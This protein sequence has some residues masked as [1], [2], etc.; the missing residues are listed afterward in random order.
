[1]GGHNDEADRAFDEAMERGFRRYCAQAPEI[2]TYSGF[3]E[4]DGRLPRVDHEGLAETLAVL[5]GWAHEL[6]E[7]AKRGVSGDRAWDAETLGRIHQVHVW[8]HD[9]LR[10][11]EANPDAL[12]D[13]GNLFFVSAFADYA[14][15]DERFEKMAQRLE[16]IPAYLVQTRARVTRP[17][18]RWCRI[19][20]EVAESFPELTD[21]LIADARAKVPGSLAERI[22]DSA[23]KARVAALDHG[24]W[25]RLREEGPANWP[26]GRERFA[27]LLEL[28]GLPLS[29]D[30]LEELGLATLDRLTRERAAVAEQIAPGRGVEA[31]LAIV[32]ADHPK[33]FDEAIGTVRD[34]VAESRRKVLAD[35]IAA[36]DFEERI[37]VLETPTFMRPLTP[38]AAI[39]PAAR[40]AKTQRGLYIV[41]PP[42]G[43]EGLKEVH[44]ADLRNVVC[45]EGYPGHH[46][47]LATANKRCSVVR[48]VDLSF[49]PIYTGTTWA[50]DLIEGWAHYCEPMMK[51]HGF[52]DTPADRLVLLSDAAWR[53][54]R[55]VL[56]VRLHS[57]K[58]DVAG[59]VSFL[60]EKSGM[61]ERG[62]AAE[63]DRYT[64]TPT[65]QL[66]YLLG[67]HLLLELKKDFAAAGKGERAFHDFVL[68]CGSVPVS[69]IRRRWESR[70]RS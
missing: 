49:F 25:C 10:P 32:K 55:M 28:K 31:A 44:F 12:G 29:V 47:Q 26:I 66:S 19:A 69:D 56:D 64:M 24:R 46:L 54:A 41:T 14:S 53:A 34:L 7:I 38:F 60:R 1:M 45:H 17:E 3:T 11:S 30:E 23:S 65:Y 15:P 9:E 2:A 8:E 67:K 21:A 48:S 61:S 33:S 37:E 20:A 52:H 35:G 59:A 5:G 63:V 58:I 57:G 6:S 13:V 70:G 39:F 42:A 40:H 62:A 16:A 4:H 43:D 27:R 51:E 22:Y 68:G 18:P 36:L 50:I